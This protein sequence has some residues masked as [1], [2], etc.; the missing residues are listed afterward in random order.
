MAAKYT[1]QFIIEGEN[2]TTAAFREFQRDASRADERMQRLGRST[3]Y[4]HANMRMLRGGVGQLGHQV[5]D[6]AIQLQMGTNGLIVFGQQG[7]QI[8]SLFGPGGALLGAVIGVGAALGTAFLPKLFETKKELKE[9]GD[10]L[11][12]AAGGMDKL[13]EAQRRLVMLT[14][15]QKIL[16]Q[17]TA[18]RDA[19]NELQAASDRYHAMAAAIAAGRRAAGSLS[20]EMVNQSNAMQRAEVEAAIAEATLSALQETMD[21]LSGAS[22]SDTFVDMVLA[23]N[24]QYQELVLN[25]EALR[26]Y[27][28]QIEIS[29]LLTS[30]ATDAQIAVVRALHERIN[31]QIRLNGLQEDGPEMS[32]RDVSQAQRI[33]DSLGSQED[34][35]RASY[36]RQLEIIKEA[37]EAQLDLGKDYNEIEAALYKQMLDDV[38]QAQLNSAS[39]LIGGFQSQ[40]ATLQGLF[41]EGSAMAKAFFLA[42]QTMAAA[43]AIIQGHSAGMNVVENATAIGL[44]PATAATLGK[45]VTALGYASAGAIM[46]QTLASFEGGGY[47]GNGARAGGLD[48]KGGYMAMLHPRETVVDHTKGVAQDG[49]R[50]VNVN[51]TIMAN[52]T[53][54]FDKLLQSRRGMIYNMVSGAVRDEG[55]RL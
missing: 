41:A 35:I 51:F 23:L 28:Q 12:S 20:D 49:G 42:Q 29:K 18:L 43:N 16:E 40:F 10:E 48:G 36:N 2:R 30:G 31:A 6:I 17:Q 5:Q 22:P 55:R 11:V 52:D 44:D 50:T 25:E 8:A 24:K 47:T 1:T 45:T 14:T 3:R 21:R 54:D 39:S 34:Q 13:T 46:G 26:L 53:R 33:A 19:Q 7:A 38:Q 15:S 32:N 37:R 27:N 9:L 4:A